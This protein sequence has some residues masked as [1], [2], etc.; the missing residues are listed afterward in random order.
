MISEFINYVIN[1]NELKMKKIQI[2]EANLI[3]ALHDY[4]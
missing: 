3:L 1:S 2:A 4:Y